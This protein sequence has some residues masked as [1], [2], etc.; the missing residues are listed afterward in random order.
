MK[1]SFFFYTIPNYAFAYAYIK[2]LA[3]LVLF[4][5]NEGNSRGWKLE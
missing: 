5:M 3:I 2:S 1:L 4:C